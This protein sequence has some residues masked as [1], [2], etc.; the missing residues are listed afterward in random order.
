MQ[1]TSKKIKTIWQ[2]LK[3]AQDRQKNY[4]DVRRRP[5][6][7][8]VGDHVFIRV[9]P[10]KGQVKFGKMGNVTTL[11]LLLPYLHTFLHGLACY[12]NLK[13][14]SWLDLLKLLA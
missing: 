1:D 5:L 4:A 10:M 13:V 3:T 9:S 2:R 6:E 8:E 12:V 11:T 14:L 7:Y